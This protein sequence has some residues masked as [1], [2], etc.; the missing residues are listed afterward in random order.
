MFFRMLPQALKEKSLNECVDKK[1]IEALQETLKTLDYGACVPCTMGSLDKAEESQSDTNT[2]ATKDWQRVPYVIYKSEQRF[3]SSKLASEMGTQAQKNTDER[4]W[5]KM[6]KQEMTRN[7]STT[8]VRFLESNGNIF[9][10]DKTNKYG[11][12]VWCD[13]MFHTLEQNLFSGFEFVTTPFMYKNDKSFLFLLRSKNA[14]NTDFETKYANEDEELEKLLGDIYNDINN[15]TDAQK[16]EYDRQVN[17][18]NSKFIVYKSGRVKVFY[19]K[20]WW[21]LV[22]DFESFSKLK[23][24]TRTELKAKPPAIR[25]LLQLGEHDCLEDKAFVVSHNKIAAPKTDISGNTAAARTDS[26]GDIAAASTG[27]PYTV[28][29]K[30]LH[31]E[32]TLRLQRKM[33]GPECPLQTALNITVERGESQYVDLPIKVNEFHLKRG[34]TIVTRRNNKEAIPSVE[35]GIVVV[36]TETSLPLMTCSAFE[37]RA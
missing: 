21:I 18:E 35:V 16:E 8:H 22:R 2:S 10:C 5:A 6:I 34:M 33:D 7:T 29:L 23:Q 20:F 4:T 15:T 27:I 9:I 32:T 26:S 3:E 17:Y 1:A 28:C 37:R 11:I 12:V 24:W 30:K 36:K 14:D 13:D 19:C 25:H 31:P